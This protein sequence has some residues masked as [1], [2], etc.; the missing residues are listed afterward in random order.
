MFVR[1][2]IRRLVFHG[3]TPVSSSYDVDAKY[4]T[5]SVPPRTLAD[6]PMSRPVVH[7]GPLPFSISWRYG[8]KLTSSPSAVRPQRTSARDSGSQS[9]FWPMRMDTSN[10]GAPVAPRFVM[11][12]IT[13]F[14]ASVPYSVAAAGPLITSLLEMSFGYWALS[15]LAAEPAR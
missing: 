9:Q 14:D 6:A 10:A 3:T 1:R 15:R 4:R 12:W 5:A 8:L 2:L 13:P 11:I 7:I